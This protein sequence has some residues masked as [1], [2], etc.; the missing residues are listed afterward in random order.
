MVIIMIFLV[1]IEEGGVN[2]F[3]FDWISDWRN[4]WRGLDLC[5]LDSINRG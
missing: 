3:I 2:V 5:P 4:P 1:Y